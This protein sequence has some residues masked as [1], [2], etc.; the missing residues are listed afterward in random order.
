M[1]NKLSNRIVQ[2]LFN[3]S[4]HYLTRLFNQEFASYWKKVKNSLWYLNSAIVN[5]SSIVW[6]KFSVN[7]ENQLPEIVANLGGRPLRAFR[8]WIGVQSFQ[9]FEGDKIVKRVGLISEFG[10]RFRSNEF[11]LYQLLAH[12]DSFL[13]R[14]G[15]WGHEPVDQIFPKE[16]ILK[17]ENKKTFKIHF[18]NSVFHSVT[19][20]LYFISQT[21]GHFSENLVEKNPCFRSLTIPDLRISSTRGLKR[22]GSQSIGSWTEK[23][24]ASDGFGSK[25]SSLDGGSVSVKE[26]SSLKNF[27]SFN[28]IGD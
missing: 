28:Y 1:K 4:H 12:L 22:S 15:F 24:R 6:Q 13:A 14:N 7:F 9:R 17:A 27:Y 10:V 16:S 23:S 19:L 25:G 3:F 20:R 2:Y 21:L 11:S 26:K 5:F 8:L 18:F